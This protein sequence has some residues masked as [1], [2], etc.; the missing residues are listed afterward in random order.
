MFFQKVCVI[1]NACAHIRVYV[2]ACL[3]MLC[4]WMWV[5]VCMC[6]AVR[7]HTDTHRSVLT[8]HSV[9]RSRMSF[10]S[11]LLQA[12]RLLASVSTSSIS[13][14][15]LGLWVTASG[16]T[17]VLGTWTSAQCFIHPAF[18]E[19]SVDLVWVT[20]LFVKVL[21][22]PMGNTVHSYSWA[23]RALTFIYQVFMWEFTIGISYLQVGPIYSWV[24]QIVIIWKGLRDGDEG[25]NNL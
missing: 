17:W 14:A 12:S 4:A 5:L 24:W 21:L 18:P 25:G 10:A 19:P 16:F 7:G 6:V 22:K 11:C 13:I 8:T 15:M 20:G 23:C 1:C 3:C 9:W 2:S